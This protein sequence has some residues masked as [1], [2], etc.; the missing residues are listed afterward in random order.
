MQKKY[1]KEIKRTGDKFLATYMDGTTSTSHDAASFW[2]IMQE[3]GATLEE[4]EAYIKMGRQVDPQHEYDE[5]ERI[6]KA[7]QEATNYA[8]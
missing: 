6:L 3:K 5:I 8:D 7:Q 2:M 4:V 1:L